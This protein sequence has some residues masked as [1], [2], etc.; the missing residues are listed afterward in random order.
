MQYYLILYANG[1][2][3]DNVQTKFSI[4]HVGISVLSEVGMW[5]APELSQTASNDLQ[6]C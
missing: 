5:Q 6:I 3:H 1:Y 4:S 2:L